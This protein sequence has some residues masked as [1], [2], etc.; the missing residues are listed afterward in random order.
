MERDRRRDAR[1]GHGA[2]GHAYVVQLHIVRQLLLT[3][4]DGMHG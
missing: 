3:E 1:I 4:A 2:G